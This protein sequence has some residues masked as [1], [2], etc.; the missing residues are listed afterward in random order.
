MCEHT[1]IGTQRRKT[2]C[3]D[4]AKW[5]SASHRDQSQKKPNLTENFQALDLGRNKLSAEYVT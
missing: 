3:K 5:A 1:H 2:L 4:T